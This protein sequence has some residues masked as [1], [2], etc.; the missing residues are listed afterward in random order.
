MDF[1]ATTKEDFDYIYRV[2]GKKPYLLEEFTIDKIKEISNE[3]NQA[4]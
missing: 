2:C 3:Q 4:V 1:I